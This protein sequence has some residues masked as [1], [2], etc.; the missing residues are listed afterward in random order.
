MSYSDISVHQLML[1][2]DVRTSTFERAIKEVIKPH[3]RVLDFGCGTGILSIF[4]ARS[5]ASSV[6]AVDKSKLIRVAKKVACANGFNRISFFHSDQDSLR[7]PTEVDVIISEWMGH[8]IFFERMFEPLIRVRDRYL[9]RDGLMMPMRI[10]L[11]AALV[12]DKSLYDRLCYFREKPYGI[13]FS[14]ISDW[15]FYDVQTTGLKT[16]QLIGVPVNLASVDMRTCQ[17]MPEVLSGSVRV[18]SPA[19]AYGICGWFDAE[20]I[21]GCCFGTGPG[22]PATHWQQAFFPFSEPF[23]ISPGRDVRFEIMPIADK[24]GKTTL[25]KWGITDGENSLGMDNFFHRAWV[26]RELPKGVLD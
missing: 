4:A 14:L 10:H 2:D 7:L 17:G 12:S 13:D 23:K 3:H 11:K 20:L 1:S 8:F 24:D 9:S 21:D 22:D 15:L 6:Y 19:V 26:R 18:D 16:E 5:G 25:W